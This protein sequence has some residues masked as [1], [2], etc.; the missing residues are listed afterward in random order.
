MHVLAFGLEQTLHNLLYILRKPIFTV[1]PLDPIDR[2]GPN[3][4]WRSASS[5]AHMFAN[6]RHRILIILRL[7]LRIIN[8]TVYFFYLFGQHNFIYNRNSRSVAYP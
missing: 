6:E 8:Q 5:P 3:P 4:G 7:H 2:L 1:T